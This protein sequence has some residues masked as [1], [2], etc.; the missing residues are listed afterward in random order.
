MKIETKQ[1]LLEFD[2]VGS[3]ETPTDFDY[4]D[5][6]F[7]IENL[8]LELEAIFNSEFKIDDQIQDASFICDLIIPNKLLIELVANYQHSIRF[9]NFGKLVTI[10]GIENINSDNL[11]TLRKLLKNHKFLFIEPNE[12]DADYDGKFDSFK[13]IYG[14]RASTWFERYFDYL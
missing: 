7:Q 12:I 14:E 6:I 11:E 3:F 8:K 2:E 1:I 9:S 10:N 13:T 5:L 4:N